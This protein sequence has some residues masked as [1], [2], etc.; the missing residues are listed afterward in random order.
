MSSGCRVSV[1]YPSRGSKWLV[2]MCRNKGPDWTGMTM[3]EG[4]EATVAK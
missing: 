2:R 4:K 1:G 3:Q